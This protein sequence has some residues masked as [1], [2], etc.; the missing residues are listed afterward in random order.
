[1]AD[2]LCD[3]Y[4]ARYLSAWLFGSLEDSALCTGVLDRAIR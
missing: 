3:M 1:V 2:L 4:E